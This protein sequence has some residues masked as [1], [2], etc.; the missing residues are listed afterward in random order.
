MAT[1]EKRRV[2]TLRDRLSHLNFPQAGK[3][4][5]PHAKRLM[6]PARSCCSTWRSIATSTCV[7]TCF[8]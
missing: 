1:Q 4:L 6:R 3:L 5:G 2:R 8:V 7:A